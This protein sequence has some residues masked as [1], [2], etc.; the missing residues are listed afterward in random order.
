MD[1][2]TCN[3]DIEDVML[4]IGSSL[5]EFCFDVEYQDYL[6]SVKEGA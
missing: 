5:C 2:I 6:E 1:C 4:D 3:K